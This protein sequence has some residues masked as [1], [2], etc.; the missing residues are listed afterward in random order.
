[1]KRRLHPFAFVGIG[2]LVMALLLTLLV[3]IVGYKI[4][5]SGGVKQILIDVGKDAKDVIKEIEEH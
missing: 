3:G 5:Q 1:M 4:E 2:I